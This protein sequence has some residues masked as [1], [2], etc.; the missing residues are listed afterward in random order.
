MVNSTI[1][2]AELL[3]KINGIL[4]EVKDPEIPALSVLELG[5]IHD[6]ELNEEVELTLSLRPTFVGCP[7][8]HVI[9]DDIT[10]ALLVLKELKSV[11]LNVDFK[12]AWNSN[13][14][15]DEGRAKLT[16]FGITPPR[17]HKGVIDL[18]LIEN[19]ACGHCGSTNTAIKSTFGSTL[20]RSMHY[21]FDCRQSFE[22][23]KPI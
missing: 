2:K 3:E 14:I 7:A 20:C 8:I 19:L 11:H 15:S 1:D 21:C 10:K 4:Q 17:A 12:T 16:A 23:F 13:M 22:A 5:M 18:S 9:K 6:I